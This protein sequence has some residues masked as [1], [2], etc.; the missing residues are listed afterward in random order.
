M[1]SEVVHV[2]DDLTT[3]YEAVKQLEIE[4]IYFIGA[5]ET[6]ILSENLPP[7]LAVAKSFSDLPRI[8]G[9]A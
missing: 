6:E 7:L 9:V 2:G 3:D 1:G 5:T 8:I 4:F